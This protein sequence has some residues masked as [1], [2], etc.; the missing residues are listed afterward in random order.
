MTLP[1]FTAARSLDHMPEW[2]RYRSR[3]DI[4][5]RA[6]CVIPQRFSCLLVPVVVERYDPAAPAGYVTDWVLV[7]ICA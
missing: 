3:A 6:D 7:P 4:G 2:Y 1:G 5:M